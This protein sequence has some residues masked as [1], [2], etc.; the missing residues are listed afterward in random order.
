MSDS[1]VSLA[2]VET[3]CYKCENCKKLQRV[4]RLKKVTLTFLTLIIVPTCQSMP[5]SPEISLTYIQQQ[6]VQVING[7]HNVSRQM[8]QLK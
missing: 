6:N 2:V 7:N 3:T 5:M 4:S 8:S 1:N